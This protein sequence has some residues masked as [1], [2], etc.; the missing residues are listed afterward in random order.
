MA[1]ESFVK[2]TILAYLGNVKKFG[3]IAETAPTKRLVQL[4]LAIANTW[5]EAS[6]MLQGNHIDYL[7]QEVKEL[8]QKVNAMVGEDAEDTKT[9]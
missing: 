9:D 7:E 2:K 1:E 6:E 8:K 3:E 5:L 4:Y